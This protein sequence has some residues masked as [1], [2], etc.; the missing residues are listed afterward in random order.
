MGLFR[1]YAKFRIGKSIFD[2]VLRMFRGRGGAS[3]GRR[4]RSSR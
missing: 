3:T 2:R 1:G 4:Q